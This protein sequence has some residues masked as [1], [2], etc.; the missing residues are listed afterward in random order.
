MT[1]VSRTIL[2]LRVCLLVCRYIL[3]CMATHEPH[4]IGTS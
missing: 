2:S 4:F 1:G 3:F